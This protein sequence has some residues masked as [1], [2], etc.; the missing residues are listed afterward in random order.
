MGEALLGSASG[1]TV[2][3]GRVESANGS[4]ALQRLIAS[5][6]PNH[7]DGPGGVIV[8]RRDK[9]RP[10]RVTVTPLRARGNIAEL[11][12]LGIDVPVAMITISDPATE[13]T[14]N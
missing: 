4:G 6:A 3:A 13:K 10:L 8:L 14:P 1:L 11:P 9:R 7:R 12:W 5:C 2:R